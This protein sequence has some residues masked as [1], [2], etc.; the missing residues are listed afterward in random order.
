MLL[1]L[2]VEAINLKPAKRGS[3]KLSQMGKMGKGRLRSGMQ[4]SLQ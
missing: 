1:W 2:I 3:T 4:T